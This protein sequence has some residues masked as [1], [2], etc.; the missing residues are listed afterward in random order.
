[1]RECLA[2]AAPGQ[3]EMAI[4]LVGPPSASSSN[5]ILHRRFEQAVRVRPLLDPA[6]AR[7]PR[8]AGEMMS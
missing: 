7:L 8:G 5:E 3:H 2:T 1:M 4:R 6:V